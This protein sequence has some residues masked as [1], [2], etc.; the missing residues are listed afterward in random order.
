MLNIEEIVKIQTI[1]KHGE[2]SISIHASPKATMEKNKI[3]ACPESYIRLAKR[4]G[5]R[6]NP[7][8][9]VDLLCRTIK[10][11][12]NNGAQ[13]IQEIN[14]SIGKFLPLFNISTSE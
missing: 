10:V 12:S 11:S 14:L 1:I 8:E 3:I 2:G 7:E 13:S 9:C 6:G 5:R 4:I